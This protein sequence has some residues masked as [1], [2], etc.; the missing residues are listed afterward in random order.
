MDCGVRWVRATACACCSALSFVGFRLIALKEAFGNDFVR[1]GSKSFLFFSTKLFI[2]I[3]N[4]SLMTLYLRKF[5]TNPEFT[6]LSVNLEI[7]AIF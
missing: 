2:D 7:V 3:I 1:K 6:K 4:Y 5:F